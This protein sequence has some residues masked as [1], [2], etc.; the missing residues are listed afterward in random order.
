MVLQKPYFNRLG[1]GDRF[2]EA[3]THAR[4]HGQFGVF[5][6]RQHHI[7]RTR[8]AANASADRGSFATAGHRSDR[9]PDGGSDSNF[10]RIALA[11]GLSLAA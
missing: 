6:T 2:G 3:E 4:L 9:G 7:A 5:P 8:R 10:R 11:R 1:D